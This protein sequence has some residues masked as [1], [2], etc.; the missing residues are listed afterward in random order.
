MSDRK[1][2]LKELDQISSNEELQLARAS[3]LRPWFSRPAVWLGGMAVGGFVLV[4]VA[5]FLRAAPGP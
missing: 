2:F 5:M 1:E 4:L 3:G